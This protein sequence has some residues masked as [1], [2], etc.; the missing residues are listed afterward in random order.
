VCGHCKN[1]EA[2]HHIN[3]SCFH[4]CAPG[5]KPEDETCKTGKSY[6]LHRLHDIGQN[7]I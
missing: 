5:Y 4:G 6:E 1:N 3:G 7:T 2:C